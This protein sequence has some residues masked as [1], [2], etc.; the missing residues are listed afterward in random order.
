M[1]TGPTIL[2]RTRAAL[3]RVRQILSVYVAVGVAAVAVII[4]TRDSNPEVYAAGIGRVVGGTAIFVFAGKAARGLRSAFTRVRIVS[5]IVTVTV[6]PVL[7]V[8]GRFPMW[9]RFEQGCSGLIML[10]VVLIVNGRSRRAAFVADETGT[11]AQ[12][13]DASPHPSARLAAAPTGNRRSR[14]FEDSHPTMWIGPRRRSR[15]ADT[16]APL[17]L[18][19][20]YLGR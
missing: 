13:G 14:A 16:E 19:R 3:R 6:L 17:E 4:V 20:P 12:R 5:G 1:D 11:P 2:P 7:I 15:P 8:P 10:G 9:L 18:V